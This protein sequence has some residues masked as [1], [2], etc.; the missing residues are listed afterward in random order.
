MRFASFILALALSGE[1]PC[2]EKLETFAGLTCPT[3]HDAQVVAS[4]PQ[5]YMF[6]DTVERRTR[7]AFVLFN[8]TKVGETE[9][10]GVGGTLYRF[11]IVLSD[12]YTLYVMQE[13]GEGYVT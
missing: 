11:S 5:R 9:V 7:C 4:V 8:G 6:A 12:S 13:D 3:L 1:A 10:F 2:Q